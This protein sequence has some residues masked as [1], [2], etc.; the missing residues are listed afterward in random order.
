[1]KIFLLLYFLII[2]KT[3]SFELESFNISG[4]TNYSESSDLKGE[5]RQL[6]T[7]IKIDYKFIL[8]APSHNKWIIYINGNASPDYD[9]FGNELK[10]NTFTCLGVDF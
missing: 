9:H 8:Y 1:M 5:N 6:S 2:Y 10:I 3:F 7:S 4:S